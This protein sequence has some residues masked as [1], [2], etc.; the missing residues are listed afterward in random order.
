MRR[1]A[2]GTLSTSLL[3]ALLLSAVFAASAS[4]GP[5]W[6][7]NGTALPAGQSETVLNHALESSFTIPGLKTTCKPS[8]FGMT[9]SNLSGTGKA[10]ITS[11]PLS[12]CVTSVPACKVAAISPGG[13]PWAANLTTV[14]AQ[15]YIVIS[16]FEVRIV[17]EGEEC[18]LGEVEVTFDGSAGGLIGN[19]TESIAFDN[20]SF[21]VTGT[22]LLAKTTWGGV[23]TM[24]ATGT[25][26]GQSLTAS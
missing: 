13:L 26:M 7:F 16:G 3:V 19:A 9:I 10:S 15:N 14:S 22:A 6:K 17:Y 24:A 18:A 1:I 21:A 23:F 2:F 5:A 20:S 25:R 11:M 12:N 8:V 4:A